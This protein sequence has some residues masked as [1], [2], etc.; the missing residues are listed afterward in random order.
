MATTKQWTARN[1]VDAATAALPEPSL[2]IV[3]VD[4]PLVNVDDER[5]RELRLIANADA[6]ELDVWKA[7]LREVR[8]AGML[9][10][11]SWMQPAIR[12]REAE[13]RSAPNM[14]DA[15]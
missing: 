13:L 11:V 5:Q 12:A 4:V 7:K 6:A 15:A 3:E 8:K 14:G 10:V 2:P 9:Y 1:L